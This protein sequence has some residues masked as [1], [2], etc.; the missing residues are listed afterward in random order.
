MAFVLVQHLDPDHKSLLAEL[1][2]KHTEMP[3]TQAKDGMALAVDRVFVIPPNAVLTIKDSVLHVVTPAPPREHRRPID[4]FFAS[5]GEDQQEHAVC[6]I[7]SGSGSDGSLGLKTVKE[8]GGFTLAQAAFD[9]TALLGMP[10]SAAATGLVDEV[11]PVER[12]PARLLAYQRHLSSVGDRKAPDGTRLDA[13]EHL[14]K[15]FVLLRA[16]LGHDFSEYKGSTLV[17]RIQRRMQVLQIES[18][19]EYID[20]LREEPDQ[21]D[22]LFRDFLIGVTHF[23]RDPEAFAALESEVIPKLLENKRT[24]DQIRIWVTGCATG[25]EAYSIA[26]LLKE[27]MAKLEVAPS[28]Q[29]FACDLDD[30]AVTIARHGRYR[31]PLSGMSPERLGRW[32]VEEGEVYAVAKEIREMCVFSTHNLVRDPPFAK[33]DL[34]SC[35]NLLI[36]LNASVQSRLVRTFHYALRPGGYLFLGSSEGVA[37]HSGLFAMLGKKHRLFQRRDHVRAS[38]PALPPAYLPEEQ[39]EYGET[40]ETTPVRNGDIVDLRVRHALEK[41]SPAYLVINRQHEVVRFSG[42]TG[43]YIEHSPGA[44]SLNLFGILRKE[45]RA[46]VRSAV[47]DAAAKKRAVVRE[48]VIVAADGNR[49]IVNLIVEPIQTVP[50]TALYVIAF[51]ER[52]SLDRR[53]GL[54]ADGSADARVETIEKEL[55]ATRTQLESTIDDLETANE[56]LKSSNE[57]YQSINEEFQSTNEELESAKEE[58]QSMNEELQTINAELNS[59]NDA[60]AEVNSDVKNLLDSTEIATLF[61]DND[62]RIRSFTPPM[63]EIAPVRDS[64]RGRP[65]TDIVSRLSYPDLD[66]DVKT[67]LRTLTVVEREVDLANNGATYLMRIRPYRTVRDVISGVVIIFVEITARKRAEEERARLA[68]IIDSSQDAIIGH[69]FEGRI[70][71]WNSGAEKIFGYQAVEAIGKPLAI[72]L[73]EHQSDDVPR[74]CAP[75]KSKSPS[76]RCKARKRLSPSSARV[77]SSVKAA[78]SASRGGWREPPQCRTPR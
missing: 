63:A 2:S 64:D 61:L 25:E 14:T 1:L 51:Q 58:L 60:L 31:K 74:I 66:R 62:L 45:L 16:R 46:T 11:M 75:A 30:H 3:V 7:L 37:R 10:S 42:R 15:I 72:L 56:E 50:D 70:T 52:G 38:L 47:Q 12:M 13:T 20:R 5:L 71:S 48:D 22:L 39:R 24:S 57:E 8:H 23:F 53:E 18:V 67:A 34:I 68:A 54:S 44:A 73:P 41:Y 55:R 29:I 26:I 21:L 33:L 4:A 6:V 27:V 65:I 32:F 78:C 76:P 77:S 19:P 35:R 49:K 9:E 17:R 28:V 59:K 69:S 40:V 36:Y 43:H